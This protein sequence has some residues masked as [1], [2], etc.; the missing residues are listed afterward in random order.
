MCAS[1][2][3]TMTL[4]PLILFMGSTAAFG[5]GVTITIN[6]NTTKDLLVTVY[7]LNTNPVQRVVA[8]AI[9][10]GFASVPLTIA[11]DGSGEGHLSWTATSGDRNMRT[12]GHHDRPHLNDSDTVHVYANSECT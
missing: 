12:C 3:S 6:N 5:D 2:R 1:N 4:I 10:N 9:I 7:D 8:N 11:A